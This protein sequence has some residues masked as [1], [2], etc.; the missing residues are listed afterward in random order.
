M[1]FISH[2]LKH[3]GKFVFEIETLKAIGE[4]QGIWKGSCVNKPDG[5]KI[6]I[7]T[8]SRFDTTSRVETVLCRYELWEENMISRTEV[9]DFRLRLYEPLEIEQLLE[10][11]SLKIIG[12]WQAEPYSRV[13]A[14]DTSAVILYECIKV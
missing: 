7:N 13:E 3:G 14:S 9:E 1:Q 10:Q 8:L 4:P 5:S 12:K 2:Q 6:V 11:H